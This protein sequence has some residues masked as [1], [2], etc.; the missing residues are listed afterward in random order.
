MAPRPRL[1]GRMTD[2]ADSP[3]DSLNDFGP[4]VAE[5]YDEFVRTQLKDLDAVAHDYFGSAEFDRLLVETGTSTF[6]AHEHEQVVAHYRG[7]LGAWVADAAK[8]G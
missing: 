5:Q 2:T 4:E 1:A 7:L 6:P 8:A 3:D